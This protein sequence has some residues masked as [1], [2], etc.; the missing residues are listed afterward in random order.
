MYKTSFREFWWKSGVLTSHGHFLWSSLEYNYLVSVSDQNNVE[1]C[2]TP[3]IY[4]YTSFYGLYDVIWRRLWLII[5]PWWLI[6]SHGL[7]NSY[8]SYVMSHC[9]TLSRVLHDF[10]L[11]WTF[12]GPNDVMMTSPWLIYDLLMMSKKNDVDW[13]QYHTYD[14]LSLKVSIFGQPRG[15]WLTRPPQ[16]LILS[17]NWVQVMLNRMRLVSWTSDDGK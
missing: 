9:I 7:W 11:K 13:Y 1:I 12:F 14:S 2:V 4:S 17:S 3:M 5:T 15:Y 10:S 8:E 6:M 16:K